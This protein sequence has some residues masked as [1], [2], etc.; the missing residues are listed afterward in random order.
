MKR[1]IR[2][3]IRHEFRHH[4]ESLANLR[5]LEIEDEEFMEDYLREKEAKRDRP[6]QFRQEERSHGF[7][8]RIRKK[9]A[10]NSKE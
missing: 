9:R 3:T 10:R 7:L 1:E 6:L 4:L 5:D 2:A 8:D